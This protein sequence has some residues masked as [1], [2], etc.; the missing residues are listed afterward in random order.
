MKNAY[1]YGEEFVNDTIDDLH[2]FHKILHKLG[3]LVCIYILTLVVSAT[4]YSYFEDKAWLDSLW[5]AMVTGTTVGYGDMYPATDGGK[6]VAA[7]QMHVVPLLIVPFIVAR[8]LTITMVDEHEFTHSEQECMKRD[9]A[10]IKAA[11]SELASA[12]SKR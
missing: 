4:L 10:E 8:I 3:G 2:W 7:F 1:K 9:L 11:L 12:Q 6:I 5:W